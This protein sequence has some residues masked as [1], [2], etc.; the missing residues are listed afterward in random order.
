MPASER[1]KVIVILLPYTVTDWF[2]PAMVITTVV[3]VLILV[4]VVAVI[5]KKIHGMIC[6][7]YW[8]T[9]KFFFHQTLHIEA[10]KYND[11]WISNIDNQDL[12]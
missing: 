8:S 1:T 11:Y 7:I 4:A 5:I 6:C 12:Q 9:A 3:L 10:R 2:I